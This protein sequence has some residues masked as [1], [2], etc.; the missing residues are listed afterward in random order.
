M[1]QSMTAQDM[2]QNTDDDLKSAPSSMGTTFTAKMPGKITA[3][4]TGMVTSG[5]FLFSPVWVQD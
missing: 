2:S 3:T 4:A 5:L 1:Q